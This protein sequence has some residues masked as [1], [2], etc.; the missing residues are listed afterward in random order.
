MKREQVRPLMM[1]FGALALIL[2]PLGSAAENDALIYV[3]LSC[4]VLTA[5]AWLRFNRC[6]HCRRHLGSYTGKTCPHC[7][8]KLL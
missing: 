5:T 8:E 4:F 3:G 6:P 2:L 7:G 1:V